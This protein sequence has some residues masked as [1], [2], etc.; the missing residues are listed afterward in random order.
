LCKKSNF[1]GQF[2]T[3]ESIAEG[4]THPELIF[5]CVEP[6]KWRRASLKLNQTEKSP[7]KHLV[8]ANPPPARINLFKRTPISSTDLNKISFSYQT[9]GPDPGGCAWRPSTNGRTMKDGVSGTL[10]SSLRRLNP[11]VILT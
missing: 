2:D 3:S 4:K 10:Q 11:C 9:R 6:C 8:C 7:S 1:H 5:I